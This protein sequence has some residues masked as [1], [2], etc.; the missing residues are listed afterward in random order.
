VRDYLA[1]TK[2]CKLHDFETGTWHP[3]PA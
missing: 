2:A 3:Y 1:S